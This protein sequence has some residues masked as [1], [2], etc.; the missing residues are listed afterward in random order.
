MQIQSNDDGHYFPL[1]AVDDPDRKKKPKKNQGEL[2]LFEDKNKGGRPAFEV[3][4]EV[5]EKVQHCASLGLNYRQTAHCLGISYHT[6][7]EKKKEFSK[8]SDAF[9]VGRSFGIFEAAEA[10]KR[11]V[12][13]GDI[14][15]I[16]YFLNNRARADWSEKPEVEVNINNSVT[17]V[18]DAEDQNA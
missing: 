11:E 15:A 9:E 10:L 1:V 8:L 3:T 16:K 17:M 18:F 7:N 4:E 2:V 13:A 6:F 12:K 5:L 14:K